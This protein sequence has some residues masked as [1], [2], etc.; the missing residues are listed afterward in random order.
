MRHQLKAILSTW[1]WTYASC[2]TS[3]D[4]A[5][6]VYPLDLLERVAFGSCNKQNKTDLQKLAWA[7]VEAFNP[8]LWL[9]TGDAVYAETHSIESLDIAFAHQLAA[10]SYQ[11][12]LATGARIDGIWVTRK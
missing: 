9:W 1:L 2:A 8:Q 7:S 11:Q 10:P 6:A 3:S 12:F 4:Q 5:D